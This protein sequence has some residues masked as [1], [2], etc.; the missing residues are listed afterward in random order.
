MNAKQRNKNRMTALYAA[1]TA[2]TVVRFRKMG[3]IGM[4]RIQAPPTLLKPAI[5][6]KRPARYGMG[7]LEP[8]NITLLPRFEDL[9]G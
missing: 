5:T 3:I 9:D 7:L 4:A 6:I 1:E 8:I 2:A